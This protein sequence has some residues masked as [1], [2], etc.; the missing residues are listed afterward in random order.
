MAS[1]NTPP[2]YVFELVA[3]EAVRKFLTAELP[4]ED[5][6]FYLASTLSGQYNTDQLSK[7]IAEFVDKT[8]IFINSI[9]VSDVDLLLESYQYFACN[10]E[11]FTVKRNKKPLFRSLLKGQSLDTTRVYKASKAF[12]AYVYGLRSA[13]S[14][15]KPEGWTPEDEVEFA[16]I[17]KAI[18]A[19][20]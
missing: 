13:V 6:A 17:F 4:V 9:E 8:L 19:P 18:L 5:I 3:V 16:P 10:Y 20:A 12:V 7:D 2:Q 11:K 15:L 14:P 1:S